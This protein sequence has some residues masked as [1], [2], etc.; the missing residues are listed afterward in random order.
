MF[1]HLPFLVY[2]APSLVCVL[3]TFF[4]HLVLVSCFLVWF[5]CFLLF[6]FTCV[7]LYPIANSILTNPGL[8]LKCTDWDYCRQGHLLF[9][10][11]GR[12]VCCRKKNRIPSVLCLMSALCL[13]GV[14]NQLYI[15]ST[16][17]FFFFLM[18]CDFRGL[19]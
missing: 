19:D 9:I 18:A 4:C 7:L 6:L 1:S 10:T 12:L 13:L 15:L 17:F 16:D 2:F 8:H 11:P 5:P 14:T 3:F